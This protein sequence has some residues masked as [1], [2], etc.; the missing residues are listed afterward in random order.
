MTSVYKL[1]CSVLLALAFSFA[2]ANDPTP[3]QDF[4]IPTKDHHNAVL[5]K[6]QFCKDPAKVTGDDFHTSR[7]KYPGDTSNKLGAAITPIFIDEFPAL[8]GAG[9]AMSRVD[10][11]KGGVNPPHI[12]PRATEIFTVRKGTLY[13]GFVTTNPNNTFYSKILTEGDTFVFPVGLIHFQ[14]NIGNGPAM[15]IAA[16]SSQN[17]GVVTVGNALFDSKPKIDPTVLA[18]SFLS[19]DDEIKKYHTKEWVHIINFD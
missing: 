8:N 16:F 5:V 10:Y 3:L 15:A 17:P 14:M 18:K 4:C 9:V 7:L 6:G 19:S 2:S 1:L 12:H 13:A 11:V